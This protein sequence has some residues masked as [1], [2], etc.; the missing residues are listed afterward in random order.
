M[1]TRTT[2]LRLGTLVTAL[3][4]RRPWKLAREV[5]TLDHLSSGRAVLGVGLGD[6]ATDRSFIK[7]GEPLDLRTRAEVADE[8]LDIITG[9]WTA[10]PFSYSGKHYHVEELTFIPAPIQQPRIPIWVGGTWP[11]RGKRAYRRAFAFE[12]FADFAES[13]ERRSRSVECRRR[14]ADSSR[15]LQGRL[16]AFIRNCGRR[17]APWR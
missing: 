8:A 4:R 17:M 11:R 3:P 9:L 1:A 5:L 6:A 14:C 12:G 16:P 2:R 13:G 15:G 7:F 10:R